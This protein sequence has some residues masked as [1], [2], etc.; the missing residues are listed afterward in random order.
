MTFNKFAVLFV[1]AIYSSEVRAQF[2]SD[3]NICRNTYGP[4][5]TQIRACSN[6]AMP[7]I[8]NRPGNEWFSKSACRAQMQRYYDNCLENAKRRAQR[9]E[10]LQRRR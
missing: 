2:Q 5:G 4:Q 6:P 10:D 3:I 7:E 9:L 8:N 1:M